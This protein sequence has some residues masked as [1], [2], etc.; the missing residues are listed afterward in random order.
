MIGFTSNAC[1]HEGD[2]MYAPKS[3]SIPPEHRIIRV[4]QPHSSHDQ[5]QTSKFSFSTTTLYLPS[6]APPCG[7]PRSSHLPIPPPIHQQPSSRT[8]IPRSN[9][10]LWSIQRSFCSNLP[11]QHVL[12]LCHPHLRP[13]SVRQNHSPRH[14]LLECHHPRKCQSR[15]DSHCAETFRSN[16]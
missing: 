1:F 14:N 4:E 9:L 7:A 5:N 2:N 16:A 8:P 6:H 13:P 10:P 15:H 11:H 3:S 12:I